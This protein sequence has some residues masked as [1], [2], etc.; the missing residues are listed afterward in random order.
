MDTR[1]SELSISWLLEAGATEYRSSLAGAKWDGGFSSAGRADST[2]L[3]ARKR[4]FGRS[5]RLTHLAVLG[6]VGELFCVKKEL[7][8]GSE[9]KVVSTH[10][11]LQ[12]PICKI[13]LRLS[14]IGKTGGREK[15]GSSPKSRSPESLT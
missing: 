10:D 8:V 3:R 11:A 2:S 4:C 5:L 13:H 15:L 14:D 1:P 6:I 7:L 9:N 12:N